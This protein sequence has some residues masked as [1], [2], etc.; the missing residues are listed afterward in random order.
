[1]IDFDAGDKKSA[2]PQIGAMN[3]TLIALI[4]AIVS[5]VC[6]FPKIYYGCVIFGGVGLVLGGYCMGYIHRHG[7]GNIKVLLGLSGAALL[8][9]VIA[10]MFGFNGIIDAL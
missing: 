6:Y 1:M 7:T 5:I 4:V 2:A 9:S 8:I 3:L 10:F